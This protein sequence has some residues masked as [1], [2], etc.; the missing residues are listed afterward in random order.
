VGVNAQAALLLAGAIVGVVVFKRLK[1]GAILGYL[2]A[3]VLLG[4]TGFGV[5]HDVEN[6]LHVSELG[7][8][9]FLFLVGLELEPKRLWEM[10]RSV[11]GLG[12]I[13]LVVSGA[14]L[15]LVG[16]VA[17]LSFAGA[18]VAALGLA[19][20]STAIALQLL[21]DRGELPTPGGRGGFAILLFQ[22]LA[23]VPILALIPLLSGEGAAA[24]FVDTLIA[25]V[26]VVAMVLA[27]IVGGRYL[28]RPLFSIIA[29]SRVHEISTAIALLIV[30]GAGLLMMQVGMSMALGAFLAGV[31]LANSEYR[32][33]LEA[34][35]EPFKG[36]LLGLFFMA[37]GMSANVHLVAERP[38]VVVA[39]VLGL[40][41]VKSAVLL[42]IGRFMKLQRRSSIIMA[43]ALS[44]GGEFAFVLFG[45]AAKANVLTK[46]V[47]ELLIVVV[48]ASMALTPL[49]FVALDRVIDKLVPK[50]TAR[51]FDALEDEANPV[52]IAGF[53]R[54]GQ[55]IG[56]ILTMCK[57]RYT[58]LEVSPEQV[59][60]VRK[61]GNKIF[62]GD[63][64]RLDLLRSAKA[65]HAKAFVLAVD[66]VEGSMRV[67]KVVKKSFPQLPIYARARNRNH[68]YQLMDLGVKVLNRDTYFS[69]L[70]MATELLMGLGFD[71]EKAELRVNRFRE[72]DERLLVDGHKI[73]HDQEAL[74]AGAR[75]AL[76]ELQSIMD[77]DS[78]EQKIENPPTAA[79]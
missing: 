12:T 55:I 21:A 74:V 67:A 72:Y 19:L 73:H 10:R 48:S 16:V 17:G 41:A 34:S 35:I 23:I 29:R 40:I 65:D 33:E 47:A 13:Q 9:F 5:V 37:I 11:F 51:E 57:I 54:Y 26:K 45:V 43:L 44:E 79:Q 66:D 63:A 14:V 42:G 3:G 2:V 22:D 46:D 20:S 31:L 61:F 52:I 32:H 75:K 77:R 60:F 8:V 25:I 69:S 76:A 78:E 50:P 59:D 15:A 24:S 30:L 39:C 7:V 27:I 1:L 71:R 28:T 64:G 62:Y 6:M 70:N 49:L 53:G 18:V 4:P 38:V 56:R 68:A 36:L 58:A